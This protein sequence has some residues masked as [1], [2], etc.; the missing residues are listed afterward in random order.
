LFA[1]PGV[2]SDLISVFVDGLSLEV[3]KIINLF[4]L[5]AVM[6]P[7]VK[8][9]SSMAQIFRNADVVA[10][11]YFRSLNKIWE[12]Y[13]NA[14]Y[15]I[16]LEE[17]LIVSPD[18]LSY[19]HY[20]LPLL[21]ADK[22]LLTISAWN[23]NGYL[24]AS[25]NKSLLYRS[26]FFPGLGWLLAQSLWMEI[27][28]KWPSCCYG[29]SWDLW[30]REPAQRK[31]RD[32]IYPDVS[33]TYHIGRNGLNVN[34]YY[35]DHY[36]RDRAMNKDPAAKLPSV[37]SMFQATYDGRIKKLLSSAKLLLHG[38]TANPCD[39]TYIPESQGSTFVLVYHQDKDDDVRHIQKIC[40]CLKL[41]DLGVRGLYKGV[42]RFHYKG[43]HVLAV[44]ALSPFV[45]NEVRLN[46]QPIRM[47]V[48][49]MTK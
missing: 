39:K 29:W 2:N 26:E 6:F 3:H 49:A 20:L 34:G 12:L 31:D 7:K 42:L 21:Q 37:E 44:G 5:Q 35:F 36:F 10:A 27:K 11:H 17:D 33:R 9:T 13:P 24:H 15:V 28:E 18:F 14:K 1:L 41:W 40:S 16:V 23:D 22:T 38:S 48:E 47:K 8:S 19:F 45:K 32:S 43:S 25:S 30:L 4:D 46:V